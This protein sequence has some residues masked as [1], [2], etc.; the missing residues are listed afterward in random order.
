MATADEVVYLYRRNEQGANCALRGDVRT[1][2]AL[3]VTLRV[4]Q[5]SREA[6]IPPTQR[7]YEAFL[8]DLRVNYTRLLT[9]RDEVHRDAFRVSAD[10]MRRFFPGFRTGVASNRPLEQSLLQNDYGAYKLYGRCYVGR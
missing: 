2:D 10:L 6:G 1:L 9:L 8:L 4:L 7:M 5:D 3:W